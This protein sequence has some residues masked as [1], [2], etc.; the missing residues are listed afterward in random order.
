M[1]ELGWRTQLLL[2]W[3]PAALALVVLWL[4][5]AGLLVGL[6]DLDAL[7]TTI[8]SVLLGLLVFAVPALLIGL[9]LALVAVGAV[10]LARP[11]RDDRR[12]VRM[13]VVVL[14]VGAVTVAG[15]WL[16]GVGT[17]GAHPVEALLGPLGLGLP[18]A[19]GAWWHLRRMRTAGQLPGA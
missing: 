14:A 19:L 5:G 10:L 13:A 18:V 6:A 15:A 9:V 8:G 16:G 11:G 3:P 12:A 4:G 7:P 2:C 1:S 17:A